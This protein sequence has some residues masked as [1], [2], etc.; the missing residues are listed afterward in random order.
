[1]TPISISSV[2]GFGDGAQRGLRKR[3]LSAFSMVKETAGDVLA[4]KLPSPPYD[5]SSECAPVAGTSVGW[6]IAVP[7]VFNG[8]GL[9]LIGVPLSFKTTV[10]EGLPNPDAPAT[11]AE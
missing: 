2:T 9:S 5:A 4:R 1:L 10:P 3:K 6:K 8:T 7:M 11:A